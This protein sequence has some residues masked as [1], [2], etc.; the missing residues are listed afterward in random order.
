MPRRIPSI[1]ASIE[2]RITTPIRPE[3]KK[4]M[5]TRTSRSYGPQPRRSAVAVKTTESASTWVTRP[6]TAFSE[7]DGEVGAVLQQVEDA[8]R[9]VRAQHSQSVPHAPTAEYRRVARRHSR[10]SRRAASAI[11]PSWAAYPIQMSPPVRRPRSD[12]DR[13]G[14]APGERRP[15]RDGLH[16]DRQHGQRREH[17]TEESGQGEEQG[18]DR[19]H[20]GQPERRQGQAPLDHEAQHHGQHQCDQEG[21]HR[22][23]ADPGQVSVEGHAEQHRGGQ[24]ADEAKRLVGQVLADVAVDRVDRAHQER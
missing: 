19:R 20:L 13:E 4:W 7:R 18:V 12:L 2:G 11:Q 24:H 23:H 3:R 22:E 16:P 9:Q 8:E 17:P 14:Q 10:A 21:Q 6:I 1:S 15:H 5:P